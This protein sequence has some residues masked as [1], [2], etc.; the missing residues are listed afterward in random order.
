MLEVEPAD[1]QDGAPKAVPELTTFQWVFFVLVR[2]VEVVM[3]S[4][5]LAL[6]ILTGYFAGGDIFVVQQLAREVLAPIILQL[7]ILFWIWHS[8]GYCCCRD[9]ETNE[10]HGFATVYRMNC[11]RWTVLFLGTISWAICCIF[12]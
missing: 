3:F 6:M 9:K 1:V 12:R 2:V 4:L 5:M 8:I 7:F 11:G 10:F